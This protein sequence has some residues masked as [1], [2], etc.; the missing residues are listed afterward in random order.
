MKEND[1]NDLK[2]KLRG[3]SKDRIVIT[4]HA[5]EQAIVREMN[6]EEIK[7]NIVNPVK[8]VYAKKQEAFRENEEKYNCYFA[9]SKQLYH[10]Y[11]LILNG[12]VLIVTI[13]KI[14]R[15]WQKAIG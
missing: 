6:L 7:E 12:K 3:Y 1:I 15:D 9:Y 2:E 10:R 8:L 5:E 11:I 14:N 13:I 4:S